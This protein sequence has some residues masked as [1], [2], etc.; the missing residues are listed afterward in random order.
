MAHLRISCLVTVIVLGSMPAMGG[1]F[2]D[3]YR[4]MEVYTTPTGGPLSNVSGGGRA[5]GNRFGRLR[6]I[7]NE[8]GEGYQ[9]ELD[10]NFGPDSRGRPEIF[11]LGALELEL[12]GVTQATLRY[13]SR[14]ILIGNADI[15][16]NALNYSLRA[17]TGVQDLELRGTLDINEQIEINQ[18]GFYDVQLEIKNADSSLIA[19]GIVV[20]GEIDTDFDIGPIT[21]KGN[22]FLDVVVAILDQVGVDTSQL[23]DIFPES[24]IDRITGELESFFEQQQRVLGAG[25]VADLESGTPGTAGALHAQQFAGGVISTLD[26]ARKGGNPLIPEPTSIILISLGGMAALRRR[27]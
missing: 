4:G 5:N 19:G 23:E 11:D 24:P 16:S 12:S 27:R 10:R 21:V 17:K 13:T 2:E 9:L 6:I 15:F 1:F 26:A 20:D 14:G 25:F 8:L 18:W 7:P 3:L 22:V